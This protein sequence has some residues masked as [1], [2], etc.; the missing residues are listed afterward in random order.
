MRWMH[1]SIPEMFAS[2]LEKRYS[3]ARCA[4]TG[5]SGFDIRGDE[6]P[7]AVS[8]SDERDI[9]PPWSQPRRFARSSAANQRATVRGLIVLALMT[10]LSEL[11]ELAARIWPDVVSSIDAL[12]ARA[13][14]SVVAH[15]RALA[16]EWRRCCDTTVP[17]Q[18]RGA[19]ALR[20]LESTR[21]TAYGTSSGVAQASSRPS[22][23]CTKRRTMFSPGPRSE[24]ATGLW[25][26]TPSKRA[27]RVERTLRWHVKNVTDQHSALDRL[28]LPTNRTKEEKLAQLQATMS[29]AAASVPPRFRNGYTATEVLRYA[30]E[31]NPD[32]ETN[33]FLSDSLVWQL[34]SGFAHGRPWA[35]L[36][37]QE[38]RL[39]LPRTPTSW[40]CD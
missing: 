8:S 3:P 6:H 7:R 40:L 16:A 5:P 12:V 21:S 39:A 32:R 35:S 4:P 1:S 31:T 14:G 29:A 34:C 19:Y 28:N 25:I 17:N 30:D 36:T 33:A 38:Q 15:A 13:E 24:S 26:L 11:E 20:M 2:G 22:R 23:C 37:F 27:L 10:N 9:P 18:P